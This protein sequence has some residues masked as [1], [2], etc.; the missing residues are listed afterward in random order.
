MNPLRHRFIKQCLASQADL[1][2][3]GEKRHYLDIGCG[4]GIFAES[5]ARL[6][7]T[8]SVTALDPS[9]EV[10][11][12][13]EAHKKRDP[14]LCQSGKLEYLNIGIEDLPKERMPAGYD[15]VSIFEVIEHV[16]NPSQFL[17]TV[18][19]HVKPGGWLIM[20][21]IARTWT[22]WLVTNVMAEDVLGIVPK[23]THDWNKYINEKELR[24]W[25]T[26]KQGWESPRAMGV[27]YVPGLGWKEMSQGEEWGN[28]FFA[29][30]KSPEALD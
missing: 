8:G 20:S 3:P 29:I 9:P 22:S 15:V 25:F 24:D 26:T 2:V 28:Y 16:N 27:L 7:D 19:S 14:L 4:G 18:L 30:R 21:T 1:A 13:A 11:T 17:Q 6:P 23:G 12:I 10:F 5:A